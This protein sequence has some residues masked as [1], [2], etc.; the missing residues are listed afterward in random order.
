M[1][2][3]NSE[4]FDINYASFGKYSYLIRFSLDKHNILYNK[5]KNSTRRVKVINDESKKN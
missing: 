3:K 2:N 5:N 4:H 1:S